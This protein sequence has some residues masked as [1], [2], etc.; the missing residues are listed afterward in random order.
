[1]AQSV[2]RKIKR[3]HIRPIW[4]DTFK[5]FDFFK[6]TRSGRFI[7]CEPFSGSLIQLGPGYSKK[8]IDKWEKENQ[9]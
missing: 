2:F 7:L 1:M 3:K 8:T 9:K 5:K 6:K 4:N